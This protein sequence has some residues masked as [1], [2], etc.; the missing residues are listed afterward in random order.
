MKLFVLFTTVLFLANFI[1]ANTVVGAT[2]FANRGA[3]R[4]EQLECVGVV[5]DYDGAVDGATRLLLTCFT[6]DYQ[7]L[8]VPTVDTA[9][10]QKQTVDGNLRSGETL[11]RFPTGTLV[12]NYMIDGVPTLI[13]DNG[14]S[15]STVQRARSFHRELTAA[16]KIGNWSLAIVR[17][18]LDGAGKSTTSSTASLQEEVLSI[19]DVN[20]RT[21]LSKCSYGQFNLYPASG[22]SLSVGVATVNTTLNPGAGNLD[23]QASYSQF[24]AYLNDLLNE[25][26]AQ[27]GARNPADFVML[28]LPPDTM[29]G[30]DAIGYFNSYLTVY[31]SRVC[32]FSSFHIHEIGHNLNLHHAR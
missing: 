28:C 25:L 21:Q 23:N 2:Y 12:H 24:L 4:L 18:G 9:W 7:L 19:N 29:A 14:N 11:L 30:T 22:N 20:V 32:T 6:D 15:T 16:R 10:I 3:A 5:S 13:N 1:P 27:N 26:S 31:N 17:V 8:G